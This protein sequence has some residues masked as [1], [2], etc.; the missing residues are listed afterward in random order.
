MKRDVT[1]PPLD[2]ATLTLRSWEYLRLAVFGLVVLLGVAV[3]KESLS[4]HCLQNSISAYYYT[5]AG[6][7]FVGAIVAIGTCLIAVQGSTVRENVL[8]DVA[9]MLALVVAFVPAPANSKATMLAV[10]QQQRCPGP[11]V[12][13]ATIARN[14]STGVT[15][16]LWVGL[17]AFVVL[18]VR[19][20]TV[21]RA[22]QRNLLAGWLVGAAVYAFFAIWYLGI[23]SAAFVHFAHYFAAGGLFLCISIV[24]VIY[25]WRNGGASKFYAAVYWFLAGAMLVGGIVFGAL[26][27]ASAWHQAFL[28][29]ET[30]EVFF[31]AV[32]WLVQTIDLENRKWE[33]PTRRPRARTR[34]L[35]V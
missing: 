1:T 14:V 12:D 5:S 31:F 21:K 26:A 24:A 33:S 23:D 4:S 6:S 15:A 27:L 34:R 11:V 8:L 28:A 25:A 32:F 2:Q 30:W 17:V 9:G 7:V 19:I 22:N 16:I 10:G 18:L 20:V 29:V 13:P 3:L 35:P